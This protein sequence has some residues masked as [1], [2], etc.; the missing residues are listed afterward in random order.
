[1]DLSSKENVPEI[2]NNG[3]QTQEN[4]YEF[5]DD[6]NKKLL[7]L[8][9]KTGENVKE[10]IDIIQT[11][12]DTYLEK[13]LRNKSLNMSADVFAK[14]KTNISLVNQIESNFKDAK[15]LLTFRIPCKENDEECN[16]F[17]DQS[18]NNTKSGVFGDYIR[19]HLTISDI[20]KNFVTNLSDRYTIKEKLGGGKSGA[21]VFLVNDKKN[22]RDVVLKLYALAIKNAI[23]DRDVREIFTTCALSNSYGFPTVYDYGTTLYSSKSDFWIDFKKNFIDCV[24][25]RDKPNDIQFYNKVYFLTTSVSSGREINKINLLNLEPNQLISILYQLAV[26]FK[27][28]KV[29]V[30]GFVHND[31]H[32]GNIFIDDS[33][34]SF[35]VHNGIEMTGMKVSIIDFD[36]A[37][38]AEYVNNL[39]KSRESL[40]MFL[41]Q[42]AM[43]KMLNQYFGIS[44]TFQI[45]NYTAGLWKPS[46]VENNDDFRL[47][48]IYMIIIELII[49]YKSIHSASNIDNDALPLDI[50]K[51]YI[52]GIKKYE[53]SYQTF[54]DFITHI[55]KNRDILL[56]S[57][58]VASLII[59]NDVKKNRLLLP[60]SPPENKQSTVSTFR[61][62][63]TFATTNQ[64]FV[65]E[66]IVFNKE[67][68]SVD[69]IIDEMNNQINNIV[70]QKIA[71]F[72]KTSI[73]Q[74]ENDTY[75][76]TK[77]HFGLH[78][79][80]MGIELIFNIGEDFL[81]PLYKDGNTYYLRITQSK[82][83]RKCSIKM[84]NTNDQFI[85]EINNIIYNQNLF[86]DPSPT[87]AM[88]SKLLSITGVVD[89]GKIT[90]TK[91]TGKITL[92]SSSGI[93]TESEQAMKF[94]SWILNYGAQEKLEQLLNCTGATFN[95]N[96]FFNNTLPLI[97]VLLRYLYDSKNIENTVFSISN[98]EKDTAKL[99]SANL[100]IN[101]IELINETRNAIDKY[102]HNLLLI[103]IRKRHEEGFIP[104]EYL[105]LGINYN[106]K[107]TERKLLRVNDIEYANSLYQMGV[108]IMI[109]TSSENIFDV[110]DQSYHKI[111]DVGKLLYEIYKYSTRE[112]AF[113]KQI[114]SLID[115][116]ATDIDKNIVDTY[117]EF[118]KIKHSIL[119]DYIHVVNSI[120]KQIRLTR[121]PYG[122]STGSVFI[123]DNDTLT[124]FNN[125]FEGI[126]SSKY[127]YIMKISDATLSSVGN[128]INDLKKMRNDNPN[129]FG[130][131][132]D[133]KKDI[134][135]IVI[136]DNLAKLYD[137]V[138]AQ[139]A[140]YNK[141]I[142]YDT[143]E[144]KYQDVNKLQIIMNAIRDINKN[145]LIRIRQKGYYGISP[146]TYITSNQTG[147]YDNSF[148]KYMKYKTKYI[149]LK[150]E[151]N[152]L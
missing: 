46:K 52:D 89:I 34:N 9:P 110:I 6:I 66:N 144:P 39:A 101:L 86:I 124:F 73:P 100:D 81:I 130:Y 27:Y 1:M 17:N 104:N 123:I 98:N 147:G 152:L 134:Y 136:T 139:E 105:Q 122:P 84:T 121:D 63:L 87:S 74:L 25:Q 82:T 7:Q 117:N 114:Y 83:S 41:I 118:I 50:I 29:N 33:K 106:Q 55:E 49:K 85:L 138:I 92:Y 53:Y 103:V 97:E 58:K 107:E 64:P 149:N 146:S 148:N 96:E 151:M 56:P 38:S 60:E 108:N 22:G 4:Y 12:G 128:F 113:I 142:L 5:L 129:L 18:D 28:A 23:E 69:D 26:I 67:I 61:K 120:H 135:N 76:K 30:P 35:Y 127:P 51:Q 16:K 24:P 93:I 65:F 36:L 109:N 59:N 10:L 78:N 126:L 79:M 47:W 140:K 19:C 80:N 95:A 54:D 8:D 15:P 14:S 133:F 125:H 57:N 72:F 91:K 119:S 3:H 31:L 132:S 71:D 45:I 116:N 44:N 111:S 2:E 141:S 115:Q 68:N 20:Q 42:E 21:F 112:Q 75:K 131:L 102:I 90:I 11:Y 32:P 40:G 137:A 48:Y 37:I 13:K 150:N 77:K 94:V 145:D 62:I 70:P 43:I 99:V 143:I 88:L